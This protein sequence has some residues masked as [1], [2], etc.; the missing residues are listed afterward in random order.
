MTQRTFTG[1]RLSVPT[2]FGVVATG[3]PFARI[4]IG[5]EGVE[6]ISTFP[7]RSDW[8]SP[9]S[10]ITLVE[11]D[12]HRV[13]FGRTD[14]S[15]ACFRYFS[16]SHEVLVSALVECGLRVEQVEQVDSVT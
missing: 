6:L 13:L 15:T 11:A 5:E 12:G 3:W 4:S 9:L 8:Y 16:R 14:G 10:G 1:I 7:L 2:D